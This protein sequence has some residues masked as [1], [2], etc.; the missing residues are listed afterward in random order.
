[1]CGRYNL[2]RDPE[3]WLGDQV[4]NRLKQHWQPAYNIAPRTAQPVVRLDDKGQPELVSMS[5]GLVPRWA[6]PE[7]NLKPQI[8]A[9]SEQAASKPMFRASMR[10]RRCLVPATGFYEWKAN[11]HGKQPFHIHLHG[12]PFLMAG[13]WDDGSL[14][15]DEGGEP[16]FAILTTEANKAVAPLHDR[17]PVIVS[18]RDLD[19]WLEEGDDRLLHSL[20]SDYFQV[21]GISKRINSPANNDPSVLVPEGDNRENGGPST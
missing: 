19:A 13:I 8:N 1:M 2:T 16:S 15:S 4:L 14:E 9:R 3:E 6:G 21:E 20:T 18:I 10:D 11:A 12:K 17:M 5:W 7:K